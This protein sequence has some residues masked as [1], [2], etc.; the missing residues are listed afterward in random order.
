MQVPRRKP[1]K[2]T[3]YKIDPYL[4]PAKLQ[5]FK[6]EL[7]RLKTT[8]QPRAISEV[9]R[10]AE[11]GD[12]SE[13]AAYQIAKGRLRGINERLE[14]LEEAVNHAVVIA[15]GD[16]AGGVQ[17]GS[18][19]TVLMAGQE[20]TYQILGSTESDPSRNIISFTS[21]IGAALIGK[22]IGESIT[23]QLADKEVAC[24]IRRIG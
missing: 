2:Y 9:K 3:H 23:I 13:N 5:E 22:K 12:F 15:P 4:T 10:L 8:A 21:P 11:M 14:E 1:G 16:S 20:K 18:T 7:A 17:I 24:E 6:D 19:V